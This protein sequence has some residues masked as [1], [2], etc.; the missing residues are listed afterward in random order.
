MFG[1][2]KQLLT[3]IG[4]FGVFLFNIFTE[5]ND[6]YTN[7]NCIDKMIMMLYSEIHTLIKK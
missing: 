6:E 7:K 5:E 4:I 3:Q 2:V 1:N